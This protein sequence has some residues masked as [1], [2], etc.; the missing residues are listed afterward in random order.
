MLQV[1]W[2]KDQAVLVETKDMPVLQS[3][4]VLLDMYSSYM[5]IYVYTVPC[6]RMYTELHS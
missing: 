3:G 2:K 1:P 5:R 4:S 6:T